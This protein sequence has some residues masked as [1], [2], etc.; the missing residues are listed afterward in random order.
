MASIT[1][2]KACRILGLKGFESPAEIKTKYRRLMLKY[3]PDTQ[4]NIGNSSVGPVSIYTAAD[5]NQAYAMLEKYGLENLA[6]IMPGNVEA[7]SS[8]KND[9]TNSKPLWHAPENPNAY[10]ARE[11]Y[12]EA[13]DSDGNILGLFTLAKGKYYWTEE[14][15]FALFMRSIRLCSESLLSEIDEKRSRDRDESRFLLAQAKLSYLLAQQMIDVEPTLSWLCKDVTDEFSKSGREARIFF[16]KAVLEHMPSRKISSGMP[17]YPARLSQQRL[18]VKKQN[19]EEVGYL[20]FPDDRLYYVII[21]LFS[22]KDIQ[23][24]LEVASL[25]DKTTK[26][27]LWIR[28]PHKQTDFMTEDLNSQIRQCLQEYDSRKIKRR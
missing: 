21:P 16:V 1:L 18:F 15:S 14:E 24:K 26:I 23:L 3:H 25:S 28:I 20:S 22:R 10:T 17:L 11:I 7:T 9:K 2:V 12:G 4:T 27:D 6:Q 19:G 13:E 8:Q 5:I